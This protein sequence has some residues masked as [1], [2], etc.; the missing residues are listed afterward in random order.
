MD[1]TSDGLSEKQQGH[2]RMN[3]LQ[4][5]L[6]FVATAGI[7]TWG[8]MQAPSAQIAD[9]AAIAKAAMDEA[10]AARGVQP[11]PR[12]AAHD[13]IDAAMSGATN[14]PAAEADRKAAAA[15]SK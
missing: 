8:S 3:A 12:T 1:H 6:L 10:V 9:H 13:K 11:K 7:M 14:S 2:T 4:K 15:M 5:K